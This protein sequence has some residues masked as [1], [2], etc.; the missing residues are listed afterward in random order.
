M[1]KMALYKKFY[2][3]QYTQDWHAKEY[4]Q[5]HGFDQGFQALHRFALQSK[6]LDVLKTKDTDI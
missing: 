6:G 4:C 5:K 2:I 3:P 1:G